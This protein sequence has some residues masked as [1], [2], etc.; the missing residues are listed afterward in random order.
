MLETLGPVPARVVAYRLGIHTNTAAQI[1]SQLKAKGA[2]KVVGN[3]STPGS[4]GKVYVYAISDG[5]EPVSENAV[6]Q[7]GDEAFLEALRAVHPEGYTDD[8]R[9]LRAPRTFLRP[10]PQTVSSCG[11]AASLCAEMGRG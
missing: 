7:D 9:S 11:S 2:V 1:M 4:R 3:A 5:E 10:L 8:P 6:S